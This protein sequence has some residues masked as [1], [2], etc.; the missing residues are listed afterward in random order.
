MEPARHDTFTV[1][2]EVDAAPER[3]LAAFAETERRRRWLRMPGSSAQYEED[4][5]VGG[6]D[7]ARSA[8]PV[9]RGEQRLRNTAVH[10]EIAKRRPAA[11]ASG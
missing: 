10:L 3:V 1:R 4:F 7:T 8:F 6:V 2:I 5:R 11:A 9:P